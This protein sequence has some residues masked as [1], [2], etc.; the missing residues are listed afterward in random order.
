MNLIWLVCCIPIVTIGPSTTAMYCVARDIAKG[1]WPGIFKTFFKAFK[2]NF[3]QSLLVFLVLLI[4]ICLIVVYLFFGASGALDHMIWLK[5]FCLLCG[6]A[7]HRVHL[8][9]RFS[10]D[11]SV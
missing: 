8:H 3:K 11:G 1:E 5:V 10:A 6:G 7:D 2:E 4:P 9:L